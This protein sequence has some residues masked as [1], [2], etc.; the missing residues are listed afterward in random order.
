MPKIK[1][2]PPKQNVQVPGKLAAGAIPRGVPM[3]VAPPKP[4][5][6]PRLNSLRANL[7]GKVF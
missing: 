4:P 3:P 6:A 2:K 1:V 7:R 5:A